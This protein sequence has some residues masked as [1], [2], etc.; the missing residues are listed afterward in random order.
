MKSPFEAELNAAMG[1]DHPSIAAYVL[2]E[3]TQVFELIPDE[4]AVARDAEGDGKVRV[5][6]I[7]RIT[8]ALLRAHFD[9]E[10]YW[11]G[12]VDRF[13]E[14]QVIDFLRKA[15][16]NEHHSWVEVW[17][18]EKLLA[19]LDPCHLHSLPAVS[20]YLP[21]RFEKLKAHLERVDPKKLPVRWDLVDAVVKDLRPYFARAS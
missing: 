16:T 15:T 5:P 9:D 6:E 2:S 1:T 21:E 13:L 3:A 10:A 11:L 20:I 14:F 17:R 4:L 7:A 19:V 18:K 8:A 12:K